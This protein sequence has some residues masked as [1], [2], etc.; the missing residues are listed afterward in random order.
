MKCLCGYVDHWNT[1]ETKEVSGNKG[2]FK[3]TFAKLERRKDR[4]STET[5]TIYGCPVCGRVF[6]EPTDQ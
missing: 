5:A 3:S 2:F 1:D 6:I 4:W